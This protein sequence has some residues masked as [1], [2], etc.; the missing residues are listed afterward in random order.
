[1]P[2]GRR[3]AS[4]GYDGTVRLWEAGSGRELR[5]LS[6]H[7]GGVWS[8]SF[9]P[10]GRRLASAGNDGTVRLWEAES[11][12]ELRA[13]SGHNN[14]VWS[15]SFSPD[16]RRLASAGDDGIC[17]WG[18]A[19]NP[20]LAR[21][22]IAG[23]SSL[24]ST[25][26]GYCLLSGEPSL[27]GLSVSRPERP[28]T[29]LY[30]P[31]GNALR[32]IL[33]RPDK[34]KAAL[35]GEPVDSSELAA[36]LAARG[37]AGGEPWDGERHRL[38]EAAP[39]APTRPPTTEV[40]PSSPFRPG[41]ALGDTG[42]LVGREATVRELLA[43]VTGRSPAILLGPRR[44]GKT[45]LLEHVR[46]RLSG[47]YTVQ[48]E[49]LQGRPPRSADDLALLLEPELADST[50]RGSSPGAE[51]LRKLGNRSRTRTRKGA[52]S[53]PK[54]PGHVYLLDEVAALEKGDETLFPWL[55][56]LGQRHASLV[57]A[58]SHWDWVRVIRRATQ[59]CPG[60]SFGNDFTSVVLDQ[61]PEEE[62]RRF[63]TQTVPGLIK[64]HVADWVLELCGAWP[65]YLQ[66]MGHALYFADAAGNRKPFNDKAALAEL[67]D[68][69]LL[70]ERSA[71]F[72]DRLRELPEPVRKLLFTH[73][74][75]R[76]EFHALPPDERTLLVDAGLCTE[77]G[78]WLPDRPFFEWLR[79]R[80]DALD[81]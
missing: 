35:A 57:L 80:A 46:E 33:H 58:G 9:S 56:E 3:L 5:S 15:V 55:R 38:P 48:Y 62:A 7:N 21:L 42:L 45:W 24:V 66:V 75:Q 79:R 63:L 6:G 49:S 60:S 14:N 41:S 10:D 34:V 4:A 53:Q 40:L 32:S 2:D 47:Q 44:A 65:F 26:S 76:P 50:P 74:G 61:I 31:L 78:R 73:R 64:E 13:L 17:V 71:V 77:A 81:T 68:Q 67:Y 22:E 70:V 12:R 23:P 11:G 16:G 39:Q 30:L 37:W 25:P 8:V 43:L 20:L 18:T 72:E 29:V 36:E 1:Y 19:K 59:V 27:H 54:A 28:E 51:L 69:R 52:S